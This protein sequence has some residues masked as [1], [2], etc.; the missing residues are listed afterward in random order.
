[1]YDEFMNFFYDTSD[2]P[3]H[4]NSPTSVLLQQPLGLVFGSYRSSW[5]ISGHPSFL[6]SAASA[7][8]V[9][10]Y[11]ELRC[12]QHQFRCELL[13]M[14]HPWRTLTRLLWTVFQ[15]TDWSTNIRGKGCFGNQDTSKLHIIQV[16]A[17]CHVENLI[18]AL[19]LRDD[20]V[21]WPISGSDAP[22]L[23]EANVPVGRTIFAES[24]VWCVCIVRYPAAWRQEIRYRM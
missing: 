7:Q 5:T 16:V 18:H 11:S 14:E 21:P 24:D 8:M 10:Q 1:M 3:A 19:H 12:D 17:C 2:S 13:N 22:N 15:K 9:F 23:S 4:M 20:V 6:R